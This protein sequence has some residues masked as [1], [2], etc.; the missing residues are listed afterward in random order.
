MPAA[1]VDGTGHEL[2][3]VLVDLIPHHR[4]SAIRTAP[5]LR[6]R[7]CPSMLPHVGTLRAEADI[8]R[9]IEPVA[10]VLPLVLAAVVGAPVEFGADKVHGPLLSHH[11]FGRTRTRPDQPHG[12][13]SATHSKGS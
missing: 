8:H 12:S 3:P 10:L 5:D 7:G 13:G 1:P 4:P 9:N 2:I 6:R 11:C